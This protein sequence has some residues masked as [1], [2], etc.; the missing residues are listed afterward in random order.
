MKNT[1]SSHK[2]QKNPHI[3]RERS[4]IGGLT[5]SVA[6]GT[7]VGLI[8]FLLLILIFSGLC[9][10]LE[11]PHSLT[12]ALSLAAI[13]LSA[14]ASGFVSIRKNHK[15]DALLCGALTGLTFMLALCALLLLIP[16]STESA[17]SSSFV[18]RLL[19]L[20]FSVLGSF[21]GR[22]EKKRKGHKKL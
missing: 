8:C 19:V 18:L 14:L 11:N 22:I 6:T 10:A 16:T 9:L 13:Y 15:R 20:P 2:A 1:S 17:P 21:L 12:F 4:R 7:G 3:S 5:V